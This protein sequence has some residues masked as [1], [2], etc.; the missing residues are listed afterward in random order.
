MSPFPY[1]R[2]RFRR[3]LSLSAALAAGFLG[4]GASNTYSRGTIVEAGTLSGAPGTV[5]SRTSLGGAA[6]R[7]GTSDTPDAYS[8][9]I[10]GTGEVVVAVPEPSAGWL[11]AAGVWFLTLQRLRRRSRM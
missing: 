5:S 6:L 1:L 9:N 3:S 7:P 8:A 11:V 2:H 4:L 10:L